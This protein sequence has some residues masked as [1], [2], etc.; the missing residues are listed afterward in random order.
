MSQQRIGVL[1]VC[2]GNICRSP[3]AE[4]V[5]LQ[6]VAQRKISERF[7]IDSAG[8]AGY[9]QGELADRR[10]LQVLERVGAPLPTRSRKVVEGDFHSFDWIFAMDTANYRDL[11]A[12][13]PAQRRAN[14]HKLLEWNGGG[15][16]PDPYYG[17]VDGFDRVHTLVDA[18][19]SNWLKEMGF[20]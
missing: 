7:T 17:G 19:I 5:M 2:L 1:F 9:H 13:A 16:V 10:T 15:D 6:K 12:R 14:I 4:G 20:E 11:L 18:A 3:M 8:T